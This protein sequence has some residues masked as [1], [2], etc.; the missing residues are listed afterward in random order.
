METSGDP[1]PFV[2]FDPPSFE[3]ILD[4]TLDRLWERKIRHTLQ[5][6]EE[7]EGTLIRLEED[8]EGMI[9]IFCKRRIV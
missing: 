9:R 7:M 5:R 1:H 8:L 6:L 3:T 2:L 4:E